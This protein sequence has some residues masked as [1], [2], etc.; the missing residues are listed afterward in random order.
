MSVKIRAKAQDG[1]INIKCLIK[2][3]ME[4]GL[5]KDEKNEIIEEHFIREIV[6]E[7]N[8]VAFMTADWNPTVSRN[9]YLHLK[10]VGEKGDRIRITWKD[11]KGES[12]SGSREAR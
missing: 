2:H 4:T 1:E 8:D 3:P 12:E 7:K 6:A 9:P 11:N 5:R 10:C